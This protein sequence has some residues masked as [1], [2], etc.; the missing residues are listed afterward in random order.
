MIQRFC[1]PER[2]AGLDLS[3]A[4]AAFCHAH[5]TLAH[6]GF[7]VGD[8]EHLPLRDASVDV[9][10]N[11]ESSHYY[12][13]LERFLHETWRALAPGGDFLYADILPADVWARAERWLAAIGFDCLRHDDISGNVLLSC[14]AIGKIRDAKQQTGLYDTFLVVPGS[15]EFAALERGDTRYKTLHLRKA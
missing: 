7:V 12:P 10:L 4:N 2:L 11:L 5:H 15:A 9:V 3:A 14:T 13:D 1:A 8:V 6:G